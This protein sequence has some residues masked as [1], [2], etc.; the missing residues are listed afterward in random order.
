M[1]AELRKAFE[2]EMAVARSRYKKGQLNQASMHLET[3]HVLGQ[4]YLLPHVE[5]HWW[6]LKI[7]HKQ[8]AVSEVVGQAIRIVLGALGSA[9]GIVPT[10]NTGGTDI[11]MF[12]Q[13]PLDPSLTEF[14]K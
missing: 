11:S 13:L 9:V 8:G 5:T 7:G 10:G 14:L 12:K 1:K 3:A 2:A 6:M 4:R